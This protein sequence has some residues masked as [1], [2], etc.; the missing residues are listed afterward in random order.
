MENKLHDVVLAELLTDKILGDSRLAGESV[1]VTVND[2][3]IIL[4]GTVDTEEQR[5]LA[6][7]LAE[8]IPGVRW[9][10]DEIVVE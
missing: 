7:E 5:K 3:T 10:E 9:V 6:I 1:T 4:S 8:G 2:G